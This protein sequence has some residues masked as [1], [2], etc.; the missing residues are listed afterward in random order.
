MPGPLHTCVKEWKSIAGSVEWSRP[1]NSDG[2]TDFLVPLDIGG[3]TIEGLFLRGRANEFSPDRDVMFQLELASTS[4]RTRIPLL[5]IDWFPR[6]A[7]HKNPDKNMIYGSHLH[8][9]V[10]NWQEGSQQMA[11]GNLPWAEQVGP[12]V[13]SFGKLLDLMARKFRISNKEAIPVPGWSPKLL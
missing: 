9:F 5:R 13:D 6:A 3:V 8:P 1:D 11:K 2:T 10:A 12:S 4:S 7:G